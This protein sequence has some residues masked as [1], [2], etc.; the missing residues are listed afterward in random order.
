MKW[1]ES[2]TIQIP[3]STFVYLLGTTFIS[4]F[5]CSLAANLPEENSSSGIAVATMD[6][7]YTLQNSLKTSQFIMKLHKR[8]Y[9][10]KAFEY[11]HFN[12]SFN[13]NT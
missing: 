11:C 2:E 6:R 4:L 5:L 8:N 9:H 7:L 10:G 1:A 13:S 12:K 3:N